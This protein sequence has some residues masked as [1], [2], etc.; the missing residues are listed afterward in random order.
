MR[1]AVLA[2]FSFDEVETLCKKQMSEL[3][4]QFPARVACRTPNQILRGDGALVEADGALYGRDII[5]DNVSS[6]F[7]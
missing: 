3:T 2:D 6:D 5:S 1:D 4:K 7:N